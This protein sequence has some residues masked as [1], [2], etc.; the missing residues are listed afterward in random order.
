MR[1]KSPLECGSPIAFHPTGGLGRRLRHRRWRRLHFSVR[2]TAKIGWHIAIKIAIIKF[3][4]WGQGQKPELEGRRRRCNSKIADSSIRN[5]APDAD[6]T[7]RPIRSQPMTSDPWT[8]T[9]QPT[10]QNKRRP[11]TPLVSTRFYLVSSSLNGFHLV[12]PSF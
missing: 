4:F 3:R 8:G 10:N 2:P 9:D 11:R 5:P 7:L 6:A 1:R 12:L